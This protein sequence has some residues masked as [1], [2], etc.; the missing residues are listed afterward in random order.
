[1]PRLRRERPAR[2][3]NLEMTVIVVALNIVTVG[4]LYRKSDEPEGY[5]MYQMHSACKQ[6]GCWRMLSN[7]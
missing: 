6:A 1:M 7:D 5:P 4:F 2:V 3:S